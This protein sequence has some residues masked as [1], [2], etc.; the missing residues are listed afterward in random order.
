[1]VLGRFLDIGGAIGRHQFRT[2]P[3]M[4]TRLALI[5]SI[6][7]VL[8]AGSAAALVNTQA[9]SG[10][11]SGEAPPAFAAVTTAADSTV[12]VVGESNAATA[13][14]AA[15]VTP[16]PAGVETAVVPSAGAQHVFDVGDSGVVTL[17]AGATGTLSLVSATPLAGWQV[18]SA[19]S[20]SVSD[21]QVVF[22][23]ATL[24]VT[25]MAHLQG[26]VV[27]TSVDA[28]ALVPPTAS[29]SPSYSGGGYSD[30][31]S[32]DHSDDSEL[33]DDHGGESGDDD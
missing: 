30:D 27:T 29:T 14:T 8:T 11:A 20:T 33:G 31:E 26:A 15:D 28:T 17:D 32:D 3:C 1:M 21:V 24:Q 18:A 10:S 12:P 5:L 25:F 6:G 23:S 9:L 13:P 22:R 7:G 19:G 16:K 4:K 2:V